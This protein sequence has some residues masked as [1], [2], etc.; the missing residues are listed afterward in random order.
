MGLS[1][2]ILCLSVGAS[3]L[4]LQRAPLRSAK[5]APT[6]GRVTM[7]DFGIMAGTKFSFRDEWA[8]DA[9]SGKMLD[10]ISEVKIE[11]YMNEQG[12]RHKM[13]KTQKERDENNLKLGGGIFPE[14]SFTIPLLNVVVNIG[15]PET[16]SIWE[17]LGFTA[18]SNN[19]ARQLEKKKSIKKEK[20]AYE[21]YDE[22]TTFW[23][24]KYG[25]TKYV[26]GSWFYADQLTTD[27]D[28][29]RSTSGFRMRKGGFY[30]D[31]SRDTR[32]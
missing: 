2:A 13:N 21:K 1:S 31:G 10:C 5:R 14:F 26:P 18:T 29:L 8:A 7:E 20:E 16:E 19:E 32:K 4:S 9:N 28:E 27:D 23:R 11:K 25:Y 24:E 15:P 17:A 3:A 6:R 30:P 12:L 22:L